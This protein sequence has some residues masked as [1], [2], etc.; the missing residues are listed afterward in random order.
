M[1][2][3]PH[4]RALVSTPSLAAD[5]LGNPGH[6]LHLCNLDIATHSLVRLARWDRHLPRVTVPPSSSPSFGPYSPGFALGWSL[7]VGPGHLV[8]KQPWS[9]ARH[10]RGML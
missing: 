5:H 9:P 7:P 2:T 8:G 6:G 4:S 1:S 3:G 10:L